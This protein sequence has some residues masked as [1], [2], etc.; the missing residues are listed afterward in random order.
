MQETWVKSLG[1]EDP[2]EKEMAT[3]SRIRAWEIPRT[4]EP[5]ELQSMGSW[6]VEQDWA[7]LTFTFNHYKQVSKHVRAQESCVWSSD[8]ESVLRLIRWQKC[9]FS[10][11]SQMIPSSKKARSKPDQSLDQFPAPPHPAPVLVTVKSIKVLMIL[12]VVFLCIS[13]TFNIVRVFTLM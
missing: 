12:A 6:G 5:G 11:F 8:H 10:T 4:V 9:E 13:S 1:Q 2:L 3:H 7:P